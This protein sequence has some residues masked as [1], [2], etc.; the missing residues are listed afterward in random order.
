MLF[1][2]S[3]VNLGNSQARPGAASSEPGLSPQHDPGQWVPGGEEQI[4]S[5][6]A[7][8]GRAVLL[9]EA[10]DLH[11]RRPVPTSY[12]GTPGIVRY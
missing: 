5:V 1:R 2:S 10:G 7:R 6:V 11:E 9:H 8:Q 4:P 3:S 12:I